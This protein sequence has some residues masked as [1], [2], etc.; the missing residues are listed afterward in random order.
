MSASTVLAVIPAR[1]GSKGIPRK[2]LRLLNGS[3]LISYAI[4]TA[5]EITPYVVVSTEDDEIAE[6]AA[7]Y[8]ATSIPR[9]IELANDDVPLDPVVIH[10]WKSSEDKLGLQFDLI[11]TIQP[12]SPLVT[13]KTVKRSLEI[14]QAET[15][16]CCIT[17]SDARHLYWVGP[18]DNPKPFPAERLNRQWLPPM[19]KETGAVVISSRYLLTQG[20]RIG[21][22]IG[23]Y[24]MP[25]NE[26]VDIDSYDDW[27]VAEY[28]L[29]AP[30][31]AIRVVGNQELGLG[32]VYRSLTIASRLSVPQLEFFVDEGSGLAEQLIK[33]HNY[34]ANRV[35]N[36]DEFIEFVDREGYTLVINDILDTD[37]SYV[38]RLRGAGKRVVINFED[39]GSGAIVAD[40]VINALYEYSTPLPNQRFGWRY[41]CLRDEF[42][43]VPQERVVPEQ[44]KVLLITFGGT[45]PNDLTSRALVTA[46]KALRGTGAEVHVVLGLGNPRVDQIVQLAESLR[47]SFGSVEVYTRVRRMSSLMRQADLAL[48][49]NGRTVFELACCGVPMITI[50]QNE[51]EASHT[52]GRLNGGVK[53]LGLA[54]GVSD[55]RLTETIRDVWMSYPIRESMHESLTKFDLKKGIHRVIKCINETYENWRTNHT[56]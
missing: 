31:V 51:R 48:T 24:P 3:P 19:W 37:A 10:A 56:E 45:D 21:G 20:K 35:L 12:T 23:L 36:D 29:K 40:L 55:A 15:L 46:S 17:V 39:L 13:S 2:N 53:D 44:A 50:S 6:V 27:M 16:D 9:P 11:I 25:E 34:K 32:H 8:G 4:R 49:S 14:A 5:R 43:Q 47:S 38:T 30:K 18:L 54:A 28:R 42:L 1:G 26:A 22:K 52:F 41:V 7:M 33:E